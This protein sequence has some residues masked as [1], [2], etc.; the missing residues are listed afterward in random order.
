MKIHFL[1]LLFLGS[2]VLSAQDR[3]ISVSIQT[4]I[5]AN[6]NIFHASQALGPYVLTEDQLHIYG[7]TVPAGMRLQYEVAHGRIGLAG[8]YRYLHMNWAKESATQLNRTAISKGNVD[9]ALHFA[10]AGITGGY[11]LYH[12]K[13]SMLGVEAEFGYYFFVKNNSPIPE[14]NAPQFYGTLAMQGAWQ[15]PPAGL[16]LTYSVGMTVQGSRQYQVERDLPPPI[17]AYGIETTKKEVY[18]LPE[19][20]VGIRHTFYLP[21]SKK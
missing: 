3:G 11:D 14:L 12:K 15:L 6:V 16:V 2:A 10:S 1:L 17:S 18:L 21:V 19:I 7:F 13:G 8:T 9:M 20:K 5:G 4:G